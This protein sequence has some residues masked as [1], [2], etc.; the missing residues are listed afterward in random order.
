M[1]QAVPGRSV[2]VQ[3]GEADGSTFFL[4]DNV[5]IADAMDAI[6]GMPLEVMKDGTRRVFAYWTFLGRGMDKDAKGV[7]LIMSVDMLRAMIPAA[8][9]LFLNVPIELR[10][11]DSPGLR[12]ILIPED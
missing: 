7:T 8:K 2:P 11:V 5:I 6:T 1:T 10:T 12:D 4:C 9:K 3:G